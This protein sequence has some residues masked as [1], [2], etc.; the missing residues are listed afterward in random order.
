MSR[1]AAAFVFMLVATLAVSRG[2]AVAGPLPSWG[3]TLDE[4][5]DVMR[6]KGLP[7]SIVA[8][9]EVGAAA[10]AIVSTHNGI[11]YRVRLYTCKERCTWLAFS[12]NWDTN[13]TITCDHINSWNKTKGF[14]YAYIDSQGDAH[15]DMDVDVQR[16]ATTESIDNNFDRWLLMLVTYKRFVDSGGVVPRD[17]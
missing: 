17:Q 11:S 6:A 14:G 3:V 9:G 5:A 8:D 12:A 7:V 15:I 16:G 2:S 13:Y 1:Y 4:V 10:Q